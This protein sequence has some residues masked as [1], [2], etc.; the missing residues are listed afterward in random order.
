MKT[1]NGSEKKVSSSSSSSSTNYA[2]K[3]KR[4]GQNRKEDDRLAQ[5]AQAEKE[6][7]AVK[8]L[9]EKY[10]RR[11][12]K[13]VANKEPALTKVKHIDEVLEKLSKQAVQKEFIQQRGLDYLTE[14]LDSIPNGPE[15]S[16]SLRKKLLQFIISLPV[17]KH[18]FEGIRLGKVIYKLSQKSS[19]HELKVLASKVV[20]KWSKVLNSKRSRS[21]VEEA[22]E[23]N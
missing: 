21:E 20:D 2:P 16:V 7:I 23:A 13:A 19:V 11:D 1:S 18:H 12:V 8:S 14:W 17:E 15:P 5:K 3:Q 4:S 6:V 9:L 10:H 22:V